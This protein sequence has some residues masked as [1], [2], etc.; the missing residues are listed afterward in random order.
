[1]FSGCTSLTAAPTIQALRSNGISACI[2][3]FYNCSS[4]VVAP[5]INAEYS[6][7]YCF[8]SMFENCTA[9]TTLPQIKISTFA[10]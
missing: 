7:N 4:L 9:L 3:M 5:E 10:Q 6:H 1:M 8:Q 2:T